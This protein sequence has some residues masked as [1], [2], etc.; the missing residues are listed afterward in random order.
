MSGEEYVLDLKKKKSINLQAD[1]VISI[2]KWMKYLT[3]VVWSCSHP[4]MKAPSWN[5]Q[6]F[7]RGQ[8]S[9]KINLLVFMVQSFQC[10]QKME[11]FKRCI[12]QSK[13]SL[14]FWKSITMAHLS[15][16]LQIRQ[17][18]LF[19]FNISAIIPLQRLHRNRRNKGIL[20]AFTEIPITSLIIEIPEMSRKAISAFRSAV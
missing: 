2:L 1:E 10:K 13:R 11:M 20:V 8:T 4:I 17:S 9:H 16:P 18:S 3:P 5:L 6:C 12:F 19:I 14:S 7:A 15:L